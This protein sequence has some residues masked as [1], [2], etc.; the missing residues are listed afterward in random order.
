MRK[1]NPNLKH[2]AKEHDNYRGIVLE[3]SS[4]SGKTWSIID[5][6]VWYTSTV[7]T[8]ITINIIKETYNGFKTTLF[9][10][11]KR[12]LPDYGIDNPFSNNIKDVPSFNLLGSKVNLIGADKP[13][14]YLG[15]GSDIFWINEA[16][17]VQQ[18]IF[19]QSE[20][21]CRGF[22]I[23]DYNPSFEDHY[24]YDSVT[25]RPD[26]SYLRTTFIHNPFISDQERNKILSY[27]PDNP[28]NVKNGTADNY[29][30]Q[31]YG[32][33]MRASPEGLI[34]KQWYEYKELPDTDLYKMF[35]IDWGGTD[36]NVLIEINADRKTK[37]IYIKE[38][39]Y[40]A[41]LLNQ[42]FIDIVKK[43]NPENNEVICDSARSDKI[44]EFTCAGINAF[45]SKKG[46]NS[47]VDGIDTIKEYR[48]YIECN[49]T[50]V[51]KEFNSYKWAKE[52][53]SGKALNKPEDANNHT[54]DSLRYAMRYYHL[55]Y[56]I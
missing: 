40:Q 54:I 22:F 42:D 19:D 43:V 35:A 14:K 44:Y 2:L 16:V 9:E 52:K 37:S 26:V 50:N 39:V 55:N 24:I 29:M 25:T 7:Q 53:I 15:A 36:P 31:V 49:S 1:I 47:I 12:R 32:L 48:I 17:H 13:S 30:W 56:G 23:L 27:D 8:G 6:L 5:F 4:R 34:F 10:D 46:K 38:H 28:D 33:G 21:R 51:K 41:E 45:G 11:F 3:G 18:E 20:M